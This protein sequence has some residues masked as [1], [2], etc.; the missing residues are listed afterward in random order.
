M[1]QRIVSLGPVNTE[2]LYLLGAGDRLVGNTMYCVRPEQAKTVKKVGSV[3]QVN[4][5]KLV[6]LEPDLVLTTGLTQPMQLESLRKFGVTLA[7]FE[8]PSS[9]AQSCVQFIELG[10]LLGLEERAGGIIA[11]IR[12]QVSSLGAQVSDRSKPSVLLQ[13]GANPLYVTGGDTFLSDY[14]RLGGGRNVMEQRNS[15]RIDYEEVVA[16]NPDV[17]IIAIMG[18]ETGVAGQELEKWQK[19]VTVNAVK[20]GRVHIIDPNLACSPSPATFT[21]ALRLITGFIHPNTLR[22][23]EQ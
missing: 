4:I 13:I 3:M 22:E 15:G 2:N 5:E 12:Q 9:F 17:I 20:T 11:Q 19:F 21:Q 8:Q 6:S 23:T 14:I 7:H 16:V 10:R 1:P 18:S